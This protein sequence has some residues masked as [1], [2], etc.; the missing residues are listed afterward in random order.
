MFK[1]DRKTGTRFH[2]PS[3]EEKNARGQKG[4]FTQKKEPKQ[5]LSETEK[6]GA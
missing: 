3:V 6:D 2:R 5:H 4:T 1:E